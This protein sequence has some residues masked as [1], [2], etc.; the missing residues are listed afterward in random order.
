MGQEVKPAVEAAPSAKPGS[1]RAR[2]ER[3]DEEKRSKGAKSNG[4]ADVKS[5]LERTRDTQEAAGALVGAPGVGWGPW[6]LLVSSY[7]NSQYNLSSFLSN[8]PLFIYSLSFSSLFFF[9]QPTFAGLNYVL[10]SVQ[11]AM[12]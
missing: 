6:R 10:G 9:P 3:Q 1:K 4:A 2:E 12:L 11:L 5:S 7:Q 8:P